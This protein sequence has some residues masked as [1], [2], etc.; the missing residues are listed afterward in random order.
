MKSNIQEP[1]MR[2]LG[3]FYICE[4]VVT[5]TIVVRRLVLFLASHRPI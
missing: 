5:A 2:A 3:Y 1:R 4:K